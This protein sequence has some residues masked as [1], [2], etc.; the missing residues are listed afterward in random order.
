MG[1][2]QQLPGAPPLDST[3]GKAW[4]SRYLEALAAD[5]GLATNE[6]FISGWFTCAL[7]TGRHYGSKQSAASLASDAA[8]GFWPT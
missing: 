8:L 3:D 2:D 1:S 7:D 6:Q 4:A 5:P